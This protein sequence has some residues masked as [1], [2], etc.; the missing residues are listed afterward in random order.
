[1]LFIYTHPQPPLEILY[2]LKV[3][4]D[5]RVL[6]LLHFAAPVTQ[7]SKP[8]FISYSHEDA[9]WLRRVKMFL[10]PMEELDL[11]RV[12]D[13][14]E[15]EPGSPWL[16]EITRSLTSAKVAVF[17]VSQSFLTSDFI[18]REELP[19]L[20]ER[21]RARGV[22]IGWIAV[23]A[24]TV[25]DNREIYRLQALN[26]PAHPLDS[27]PEPQQKKVLT[28]IYEKLKKMVAAA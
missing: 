9:E 27:L 12:W 16:D 5:R 18:Q 1:M 23:S 17:L 19:A 8:V 13:D 10:K 7:K 25:K 22:Q 14:T 20:L 6:L 3:G 11:V 26:D 4:Q 21:A 28:D 2:E 24:S 15:I